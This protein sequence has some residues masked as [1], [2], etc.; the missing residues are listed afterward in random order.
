MRGTKLLLPL[1]VL[2]AATPAF[3][4]EKGY[5]LST[6]LTHSDNIRRSSGGELD[7]VIGSI[8]LDFSLAQETGPLQGDITAQYRYIE[9]LEDSFDAE[10]I[11]AFDGQLEWLIIPD[12]LTWE[13]LD[14]FGQ[15]TTDPFQ[16]DTPSNRQDSNV[17]TTGPQ[18]DFRLGQVT[19]LNIGARYVDQY[20]EESEAGNERVTGTIE[21]ARQLSNDRNISLVLDAEETT[22]DD[23]SFMK[24]ERRSAFV[25]FDSPLG[26]S[27]LS[28]DIGVNQID[29]A[30]QSNTGT[31]YRLSFTRDA[32][33]QFTWGGSV[34]RSFSDAGLRLSSAR[35]QLQNIGGAQDIIATGSPLELVGAS[36]FATKE[37]G[38]GTLSIN[39]DMVEEDFINSTQPNR[40]IRQADLSF[41]YRLSERSFFQ[42]SATFERSTF[43]AIDR[44]DEDLDYGLSYVRDVGRNFVLT[45]SVTKSS[46]DSTENDG[47]FDETR[48]IIRLAYSNGVLAEE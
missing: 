13:F 38:R 36:I 32:N 7:D 28:L 46:R 37:I 16:T 44:E 15:L 26:A 45:L 22:F 8:Q 43:D 34:S 27:Q 41:D 2:I 23:E 33:E 11:A 35:S 20:F 6:Q 5:R 9:Y 30:G 39:A 19:T 1:C 25:R 42:M 14:S 40:D 10:P 4:L 3:G 31:L 29:R 17:F 24:F 12:R 18:L 48:A 21:L 47:G